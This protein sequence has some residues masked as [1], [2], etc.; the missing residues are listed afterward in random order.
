[1][2]EIMKKE[3]NRLLFINHTEI[4]WEKQSQCVVHAKFSDF[5]ELPLQ[6]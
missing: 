6:I 5:A 4:N 2:S 3:L 1:M